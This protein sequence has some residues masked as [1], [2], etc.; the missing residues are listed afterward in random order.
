MVTE[1][2]MARQQNMYWRGHLSSGAHA[3][4]AGALFS[5]SHSKQVKGHILVNALE[6]LNLWVSQ[7]APEQIKQ[8]SEEQVLTLAMER[9]GHPGQYGF[10]LSRRYFKS[11][12]H[13]A[14]TMGALMDRLG[15]VK[16]LKEKMSD[17][18]KR[19]R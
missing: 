1:G 3:P 13:L 16:N 11:D 8:M 18:E 6:K 12:D 15:Q 2:A 17:R 14:E 9:P 5:G 7:L 4:A 10:L 19:E